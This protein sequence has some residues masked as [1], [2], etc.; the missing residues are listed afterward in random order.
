M[1]R[2]VHTG[3]GEILAVK[4]L[5]KR[6]SEDPV[7]KEQF[8]HEGRMG[9]K[10]RHQNI[11][12]IYNVFSEGNNHFLT[13][14]FVEGR[15]LREFVRIRKRLS[16]LESTNLIIDVVAAL[17]Y[18][19]RL[20]ITHRD[21]KM[22]NVLVS[23]RAEAKLV[24]FGLA[25]YS[26]KLTAEVIANHP[27]PRTID[28]AGLERCTGVRRND[29]TSD[30]YFAGTIY[31][32]MLSGHPA[33]H[34]TKDRVQRL[35]T[36]RFQEIL[37][38]THHLPD[39]PRQVVNVVQRSM[40][41]NPKRRYSDPAEMLAELTQLRDRLTELVRS[42]ELEDDGAF[43]PD[44]AGAA[45]EPKVEQE[46]L[47]RTVMLVESNVAMQNVLRDQLKKHGYRVLVFSDTERALSRF[48]ADIEVPADC[49]VFSANSLGEEALDAFNRFA[50]IPRTKSRPAMLLLDAKHKLLEHKAVVAEHR[51]VVVMPV[52]MSKF[53]EVLKGLIETRYL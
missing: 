44:S 21:L 17:D 12:P 37:P 8:L 10:L 26:Q 6:F 13:M 35:A 22:S 42:G 25:A 14:E 15:N 24:D 28:Y 52:P 40:E 20:G 30:I 4:V 46:G 38:I 50:E 36:T 3:T 39:L 49:V 47:R 7:Q 2:A 18:A 5:R 32:H 19:F 1:Y 43:S 23:S 41:L 27:N 9:M 53:R 16:A 51:S 48:Q 45:T 29:K 11:V 31:Y 33:L 34:E